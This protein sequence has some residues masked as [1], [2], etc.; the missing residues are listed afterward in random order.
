MPKGG[1]QVHMPPRPMSGE[2][3]RQLKEMF[4]PRQVPEQTAADAADTTAAAATAHAPAAAPP[5]IPAAAASTDVASGG[6]S[7]NVEFATPAPKIPL[8]SL[9]LVP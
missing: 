4:K 7:A 9:L 3:S 8:A 5:D 6:A 1:D 2:V